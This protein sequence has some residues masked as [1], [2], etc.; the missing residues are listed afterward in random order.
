MLKIEGCGSKNKEEIKTLYE[1]R[2][3]KKNYFKIKDYKLTNRLLFVIKIIILLSFIEVNSGVESKSYPN[4]IFE[5]YHC[6]G[7]Y[8]IIIL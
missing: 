6:F 7:F 8:K 3:A 5:K 4:S 2:I 1:T